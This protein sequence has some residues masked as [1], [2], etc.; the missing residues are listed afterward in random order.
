MGIVP[1]G[2][3]K[4]ISWYKSHANKWAEDP[5]AIGVTPE[6]VA[7]LQAIVEEASVARNQQAS[8]YGA[9]RSA[10]LRLKLAIEK[11]SFA[12]SCMV[13]QIRTQAAVSDD[14]GVYSKAWIPQPRKKSPIGKPGTPSDFGFKLEQIG[15][16][17]LSWTC[18]NPKGAEGTTYLVYRQLNGDG[19]FAYLGHA[20][21]KKFLDKTLP[22]GVEYV[23]YQI[24][25]VRSTATGTAAYFHVNFGRAG[26]APM[27]AIHIAA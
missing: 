1:K 23:T 19:P 11:L 7:S 4:R 5:G 17:N 14:P 13:Q 2:R 3:V 24:Q 6:Q 26:A 21:K 10:T 18:K 25:A 22:A 9:A 20:G 8:A 16:L 12:G 27:A 15:W